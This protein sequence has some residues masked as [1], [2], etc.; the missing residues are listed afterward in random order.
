MLRK[1]TLAVLGGLLILASGGL[2]AKPLPFGTTTISFMFNP[3]VTSNTVTLSGSDVAF[4]GTGGFANLFAFG[5]A[6]GTFSF[7][8]VVNEVVSMTNNPVNGLLSF[9]DGS[10]GNYVFSLTN[11][12]QTLA[13]SNNPGISTSISLYL[14]GTTSDAHLDYAAT[15]TSLTLTLNSTG[16]SFFSGSAT[17]ANPPALTPPTPSHQDEETPEPAS[18]ALFAAGLLGLAY[19]RR[20]LA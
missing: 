11:S 10:G 6:S 3:V 15:P 16:N 5:T 2:Q 4:G 13:Y 14:L 12:V 9:G 18:L 17:L 20:R 8:N 7:S 1:L 19:A